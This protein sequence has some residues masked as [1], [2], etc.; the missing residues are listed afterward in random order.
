MGLFDNPVINQ[1]IGELTGAVDSMVREMIVLEK[2]VTT[3]MNDLKRELKQE[4]HDLRGEL[5]DIDEKA[6]NG[7]EASRQNMKD[8]STIKVQVKGL[9]DQLT[10]MKE[11]TLKREYMFPVLAKAMPFIQIASLLGVGLALWLINRAADA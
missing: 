8:I 5:K 11:D 7:S 3:G 6:T 10:A 2:N 1:K 4:M 9:E